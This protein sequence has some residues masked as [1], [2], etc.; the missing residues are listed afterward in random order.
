MGP[1]ILAADSYYTEEN[2]DRLIEPGL[3]WCKDIAITTIKRLRKARDEKN[4]RVITGHDPM[5]WWRIRLSPF[6]YD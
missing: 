4:I 1:I 2:L 5:A 6:Y 3:S